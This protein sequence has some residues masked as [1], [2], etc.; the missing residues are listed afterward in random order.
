MSR[1]PKCPFCGR[2]V[3]PPQNLGFQFADMDAGFCECGAVYVSDV[4]GYSRGAAFAEALFLAAGGDWELAWDL[5]PGE[6]YQ[7]SLL[8][9]Y[10]QV[11]HQ[12]I[13]EGSFEGRKISGVLYFIKLADDIREVSREK[14]PEIRQ[15]R[16]RE[17]APPGFRPRKIRRPEAERL[18]SEDRFK[19]LLLLC[20]HQPL[21]LR[22]LQKVLYHP[23]PA[24][25]FRT[26]KFLGKIAAELADEYPE[27]VADL[28][29][30][31]L[32]ASADSAASA[33]GA[34]ETVG[35]IIRYLPKRFGLYTRNL[36]AFL[37]YPEFRPAALFALSRIAEDH[38]ELIRR[39]KPFL[40][41]EFL[42][43]KEPLVR[44]LALLTIYRAGLK[45]LTSSIKALLSDTA[46][47]EMYIPEEDTFRRFRVDELAAK[48]LKEWENGGE[49]DA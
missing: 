6:D 25:R 41:T 36:Q 33:W 39:E 21:N 45:E 16:K 17:E 5:I 1:I 42:Q 15:K 4:T 3:A 11:T 8:E 38:P 30:R 10:D 47:F 44:G 34:L 9:P 28:M 48:I 14:I 24:L 46:E 27:E 22:T 43:D 20:R 32:Y 49:T 31:L 12:V 40:L 29:K 19:E 26:V 13:P 7:E 18:V 23:E 37:K 35:E 2:P